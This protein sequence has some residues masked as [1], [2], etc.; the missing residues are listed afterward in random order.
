M[1]LQV[2]ELLDRIKSEG[3][4]AARVKAAGILAEAETQARTILTSAERSASE[5]EAA[6]RQRVEAM[7]KASR[8][9]LVQASRDSLLALREK[10]QAFVKDAVTATTAEVLDAAFLAR[11]LPQILFEVSRGIEEDISVFLSED[12]LKSL[13]GA[14]ANRLAK[15][16]SR[17]VTFKPFASL[18]AGFRI[19]MEGSNAYYDFSAESLSAILA[20]R[21]NARLAECINSA[22]AGGALT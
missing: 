4:E 14:L 8:L 12:V 20:S 21:T 15:E 5:M 13:D 18:D 2:Q 7:E 1:E 17:G 11:I 22:I 19:S 3:V 16:L 10:V 6:A 9:S